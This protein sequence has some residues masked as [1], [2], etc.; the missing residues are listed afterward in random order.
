MKK[1]M[2]AATLLTLSIATQARGGNA[3]L[4]LK[5]S[6]A[7]FAS[8]SIEE[9]VRLFYRVNAGLKEQV[10]GASVTTNTPEDSTVVI[11][12][13]DGSAFTYS[14]LRFDD[15]SNGGTV[16]KKEVVCRQ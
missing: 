13:E 14:C 5:N 6:M 10:I 11:E 9:S 12:L 4:D 7:G 2:I 8:E 15:W 1:L 16:L 3:N